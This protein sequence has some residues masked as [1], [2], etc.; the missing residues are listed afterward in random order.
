M[1]FDWYNRIGGWS[2]RIHVFRYDTKT[3]RVCRFVLGWM[4]SHHRS[5]CCFYRHEKTIPQS[6][7]CGMG[8]CFDSSMFSNCWDSI[9]WNGVGK[10]CKFDRLCT[11]CLSSIPCFYLHHLLLSTILIHFSS[12]FFISFA[13]IRIHATSLS[14]TM[15]I[16]ITFGA[17]LKIINQ[18]PNAC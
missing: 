11:G 14:L 18:L 8:I 15:T 13:S 16:S 17:H 6:F 3:I 5:I 10:F 2:G 9:G 4:F 7:D 12:L 1:F